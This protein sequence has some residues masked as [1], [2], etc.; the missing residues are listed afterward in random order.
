MISGTKYFEKQ[1]VSAD[2]KEG[3]LMACKWIATNVLSNKDL[4]DTLF[5]IVKAGNDDYFVFIVE[6]YCCIDCKEQS[7][8]Y[9]KVCKEMHKSFFINEEYNCSRCNKRAYNDRLKSALKIKRA[10]RVDK[11]KN[12]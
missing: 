12:L 11:S 6:L 4:K 10:Y 8:K 5:K 1:F 9:C 2:A 7:D 3:Y